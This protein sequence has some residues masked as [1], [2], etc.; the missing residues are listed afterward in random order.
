MLRRCVRSL[1]ASA[2]SRSCSPTSRGRRGC[3][4]SSAPRLRGGAGRAPPGR[5]E[6]RSR[7]TAAS[8]WTRRATRSSSRSRRRRARWPRRPTARTRSRQGRSGCGWAC[9]RGAALTDEGYV[10][11][12]VHRAARIAAAGHGG[13]VLVSS[14]TARAGRARRLCATSAST[15]SRTSARRAAVPAR[16]RRVPAA[17]EPLPDEP[18]RA[19]DAVPRP[20]ARA[21]ARSSSCSP[22]TTCGC[23]R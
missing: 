6:R 5:S 15:A 8:R 22:A 4:T 3:C 16:R 18:A 17:E 1:S 14:A 23:S 20:R 12:D 19:G 10:G 13:Q 21:R 9:T 11:A 2:R 7:G